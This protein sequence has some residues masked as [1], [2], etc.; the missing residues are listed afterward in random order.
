MNRRIKGMISNT[1]RKKRGVKI[2]INDK[3]RQMCIY[4]KWFALK[5][6]HK[7]PKV[8]EMLQKMKRSLV[9]LVSFFSK[10]SCNFTW[11]DKGQ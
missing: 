3:K 1:L 11:K 9:S 2:K 4:H 5:P 7:D 8:E 10:I 6:E